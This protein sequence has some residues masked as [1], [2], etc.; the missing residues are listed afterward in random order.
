[1]GNRVRLG[2]SLVF[3]AAALMGCS[4][5]SRPK[6]QT[7]APR[8]PDAS[9]LLADGPADVFSVEAARR[10]SQNGDEI[11]VEGRIGGTPQPFVEG[12]AAF[13]IVD[14]RVKWCAEDEGCPTPWD[15]CCADTASKTATIKVVDSDGRPVA[16]DARQLLGVKEL[17][18]VVAIGRLKRD[19]HANLTVLAEKVHVA[20]E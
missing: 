1:M 18:Q 11:A 14:T 12:I 8:P 7:T 15:Y 4:E 10:D 9:Y 2:Q 13:T 6:P 20:E 3:V 5:S 16:T 19:E 17:S